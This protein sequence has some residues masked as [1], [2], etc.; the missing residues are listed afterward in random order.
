MMGWGNSPLILFI[1]ENIM[2][3]EIENFK[4]VGGPGNSIA[5]GQLYSVF[6][7]TDTLTQMLASGYLNELSGTI[8][9]KDSI[10]LSGVEGSVLVQV[11]S[12]VGGVVVLRDT[13]DAETISANNA[14][15]SPSI[16][17]TFLKTTGAIALSLPD[18]QNGFVKIITMIVDGGDA[19]LTPSDLV[20]AATITFNDV[21][22]SVILAFSVAD[23][24]WITMNKQ[25][26][27]EA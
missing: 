17:V 18:G 5:G 19:V 10:F 27:V 22:D 1:K 24:G 12:N 13:T 20:G 23:G 11:N 15:V 7:E 16:P 21:G 25:G 26:A 4:E 3:F 14:V 8:N 9:E 2:S 6:S